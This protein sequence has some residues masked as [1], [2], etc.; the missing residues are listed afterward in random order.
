MESGFWDPVGGLEDGPVSAVDSADLR[1][2]WDLFGDVRA[3]NADQTVAIG[4]GIFERACSPGANVR[5][6]Y[7]RA[8]MLQ[9]CER[10][11]LLSP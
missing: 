9:L 10:Q 2:A 8:A 3:R 11:G 5:S 6:V 4:I 7:Y 1:A